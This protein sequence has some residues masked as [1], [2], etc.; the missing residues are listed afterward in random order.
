MRTILHLSALLFLLAGTLFAQGNPE[1][2]ERNWHQWRGPSANGI[3]PDGN[4]PIEWNEEM[5]IKW[6]T[7]IIWVGGLILIIW[8]FE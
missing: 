3:A 7:K 6:I 2:Y 4:P 8:S 1:D 5:N